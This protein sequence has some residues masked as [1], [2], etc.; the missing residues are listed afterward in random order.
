MLTSS[1]RSE[2]EPLS[3]YLR[4]PL[5]CHCTLD[6]GACIDIGHVILNGFDLAEVLTLFARRTTILHLQG[7]AGGRDHQAVNHLD[8]H[9]Q[10]IISRFLQDF[11]GS[12]T[13][14]VFSLE[15]L[16]ASLDHFPQLMLA[17]DA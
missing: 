11:K 14:E 12:A 6:H 13:I 1:C 15:H 16:Q 7:V 8:H 9:D 5:E 4:C 2:L 3:L 10:R 17:A